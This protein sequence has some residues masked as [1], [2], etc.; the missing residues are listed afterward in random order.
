MNKEI[1]SGLKGKNL[2]KEKFEFDSTVKLLLFRYKV[3][4]LPLGIILVCIFLFIQVVNV[5]LQDFYTL[6]N[7]VEA[8]QERI[9]ILKGNLNMLSS[10]NNTTQDRYLQS[11]YNALPSYKDFM[12]VLNAVTVASGNAGVGLSDFSF[13]VGDLST[14]S[15]QLAKSPSF[16]LNL[17]LLNSGVDKTKRF[18]NELAKISPLSEVIE[19]DINGNTASVILVFYYKPLP[20]M[21][22]NYFS[23]IKPISLQEKSL[24]DKISSWNTGSVV[25]QKTGKES[26]A[27]A[28]LNQKSG[29]SEELDT[30]F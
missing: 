10:L 3:F 23:P 29:Q 27:S 24:V 7:E 11:A 15:A 9:G 17:T 26:S 22:V 12:G 2:D 8:E 5:Q 18:L 14:K 20:L 4:L 21:V 13:N 16:N 30:P 6:Q 25:L 1:N 28:I 19:V